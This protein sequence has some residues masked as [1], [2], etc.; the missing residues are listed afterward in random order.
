LNKDFAPIAYYRQLLYWLSY[1]KFNPWI[2]STGMILI[3]IFVALRLNPINFGL[4]TG[5]FAA[6]SIEILLLVAFQI[7]YGYVYQATGAIITIFMAGLA[8][9]AFYEQRKSKKSNVMSFIAIQGAVG[10]YALLLPLV[11]SQSKDAVR[12]D[13]IVYTIFFLLTFAIAALIGAEFSMA[14]KLLKGNIRS[15][16]GELYSIDLIGSAIGAL[17]VATYIL[18][19]FGIV[20]ASFIVAALNFASALTTLV[21][22]K[23]SKTN[24]GQNPGLSYV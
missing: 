2:P 5:G 16:A 15:V 24:L 17:I 9:G 4:F 18:P 23:K 8:V 12:G 22:K 3:L 10:I 19:L 20:K 1:F 7:I 11:L 21:N 13:V 6:S 14:T